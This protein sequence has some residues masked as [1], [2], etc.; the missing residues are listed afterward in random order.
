MMKGYKVFVSNKTCVG[1][2][3]KLS[4]NPNDVG[5]TK[6]LNMDYCMSCFRLKHYKD[7]MNYN[8]PRVIPSI[9][10]NSL[11]LVISSVLYLD[12]LFTYPIKRYQED[13]KIVYI[14]NQ[15]DLLPPQTNYDYLYKRIKEEANLYHAPYE[16]I[17]LMSATHED[18]V[19]RL[20]EYLLTYKNINDIYLLGVQNSGKT[21]LLNALTN[22]NLALVDVKAGLTQE[23]ITREFDHFK[24]HDLPGLYQ[25]NYIHHLMP[26][27]EYR[28]LIPIKEIK[29]VI[30]NL[31]VNEATLINDMFALYLIKGNG[32]VVFYFNELP[33]RKVNFTNIENQLIK[34]FEY[35]QQTFKLTDNKKYQITVA[36]IGLIHL[37]GPKTI[38][39]MIP[40]GLHISLKEAFFL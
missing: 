39:M 40:K 4:L 36:D 19:N 12:L 28:K 9:K 32:S 22:S 13:I 21:T 1:C 34:T 26:Y 33:I 15:L 37:M 27:H 3:A 14:I 18:D 16:D 23:T 31:K 20:K 10:K 2:G 11:V 7:P 30:I 25:E 24:I 29:P 17:I 5:Y 35:T 38:K 8:H 6:D